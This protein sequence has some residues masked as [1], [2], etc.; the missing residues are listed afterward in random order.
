MRNRI[1][2]QFGKAFIHKKGSP[3]CSGKLVDIRATYLIP[4]GERPDGQERP[5]EGFISTPEGL[6]DSHQHELY[7]PY[8]APQ[9]RIP[10]ERRLT[11][12]ELSAIK[13]AFSAE[14]K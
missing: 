13:K 9:Y 3:L 4:A 8:R 5:A 12:D 14:R 11:S 2:Q 7:V 1:E 10:L 6:V